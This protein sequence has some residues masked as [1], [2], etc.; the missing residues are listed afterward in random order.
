MHFINDLIQFIRNA[1]NKGNQVTLAVDIN[2]HVTDGKLPAELKKVGM[3]EAFMKKFNSSGPAS[4]VK[5]SES[6]DGV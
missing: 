1:I 5:G 2:E 6:I 4:H 3:V